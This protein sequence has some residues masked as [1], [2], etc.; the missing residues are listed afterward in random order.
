MATLIFPV[1]SGLIVIALTLLVYFRL[2]KRERHL[3]IKEMEKS[4]ASI[5]DEAAILLLQG[6]KTLEEKE[7]ILRFAQEKILPENQKAEEDFIEETAEMT[8][9]GAEA[10]ADAAAPWAE[11][12]IPS[13][14]SEGLPSEGADFEAS[15]SLFPEEASSPLPEQ[16]PEEDELAAENAL[17]ALEW[18]EEPEETEEDALIWPGL[19]GQPPPVYDWEESGA[20]AERA[21]TP[22]N[23]SEE[24]ED[25]TL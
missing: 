5:G 23:E 24:Q 9:D 11:E 14:L 8:A 21:H 19:K 10:G 7:E 20:A 15:V 2:G 1:L 25:Y 17:N 3:R 6:A 4:L 18:E 16:L 13:E 22:N 12:E